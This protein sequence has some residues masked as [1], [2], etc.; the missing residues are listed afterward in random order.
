MAAGRSNRIKAIA[1]HTG[2]ILFLSAVKKTLL[3]FTTGRHDR[4]LD[5]MTPAFWGLSINVLSLDKLLCKLQLSRGR[6]R[7]PSWNDTNKPDYRCRQGSLIRRL[8]YSEAT[9]ALLSKF[10]HKVQ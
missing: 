10:F 2:L 6:K 9:V 3:D 7:R 8:S 5:E 4:L 1:K